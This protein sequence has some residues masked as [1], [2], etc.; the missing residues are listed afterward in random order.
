MNILVGGDF[1]FVPFFSFH[2]GKTLS[3]SPFSLIHLTHFIIACFLL[4]FFGIRVSTS[5]FFLS[6]L[7]RSHFVSFFRILVHQFL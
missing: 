2:N 6:Q 1:I 3:M 4:L 5:R 7:F